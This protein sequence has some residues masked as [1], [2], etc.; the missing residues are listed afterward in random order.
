MGETQV[1]WRHHYIPEFYLKRWANSKG[2]LIEFSKPYGPSVKPQ[3]RYPRE[4]GFMD[5]LYA[6][7]GVPEHLS[8]YFETAF[9]RPVDTKAATVLEKMEAGGRNF[10]ATERSAWGRFILS[11]IFRHPENV[12]AIKGRLAHD[13]LETSPD[14]ERA[15]RRRRLP[16]DP[17]TLREAMSA[18]R[19]RPA[20]VQ[21]AMRLLAST[22]NSPKIGSHLINMRWGMVSLPFHAPALLTS[23]RPVVWAYGLQHPDSHILLPVGPKKIFFAVNSEAIQLTLNTMDPSSL[24]R[25]VNEQ[26]VRRAKKLVFG[27]SDGHLDYV[28]RHMGV[29]PEVTIPDQL[30]G[31]RR[32]PRS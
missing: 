29:N 31:Y 12:S 30:V 4:T 11:L 28:Q 23:D 27:F 24:A 26:V 15:Y 5:K 14:A 8:H 19:T 13:Y 21:H 16:N 9:F 18:E 10:S 17:R 32:N 7:E 1:A 3:R 2:Q 25:F 22:S 6:I 20:L